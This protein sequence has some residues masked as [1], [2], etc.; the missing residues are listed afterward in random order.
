MARPRE[1]TD[2]AILAATARAVG[3]LGPA[4]LTLAEVAGELGIAPATLIQ[5]FGSKRGLLLALARGGAG[6]AETDFAAF[7]AKHR[8][9]LAALTALV[10]C[11]AGMATTPEE[12]ANH[13]AFLHIDLT[14]PDF[15]R[16]ALVHAKAMQ[17]EIVSLLDAAVQA[18]ELI[19]CDTRALGRAVQSL[20]GGSLLAWAIERDGT[21][22]QRLRADLQVLLHRYR[23][24][25]TPKR[26][27]RR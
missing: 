6:S 8:S 1:T 5:R 9:P 18:G 7:R 23:R 12:L 22:E 14:D 16:L 11:M 4:R 2:A 27:R 25:A 19:D 17:A 13:I 24:P 3:R 26:R 10:A 20:S 21:A 15:H